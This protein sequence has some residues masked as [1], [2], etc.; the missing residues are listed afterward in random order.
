MHTIIGSSYYY[1]RY[2][3]NTFRQQRWLSEE[4]L[5]RN[6]E[7]PVGVSD[8]SHKV[9]GGSCLQDY[10]SKILLIEISPQV[11]SQKLFSFLTLES[12]EQETGLT[13]G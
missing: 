12:K 5:A 1:S 7:E 10:S 9:Q 6:G 8:S 11:L 4:G 3:L 2:R 13:V